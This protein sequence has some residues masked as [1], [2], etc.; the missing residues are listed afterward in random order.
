MITLTSAEGQIMYASPSITKVFGYTPHEIPTALASDFIHPDD[1]KLYI[2]KRNQIQ[3]IPNGSVTYELRLKHKTGRWIWCEINLSN[4]LNESGIDAMVA[5]FRD[6]SDKKTLEQEK[7]FD[8]NNLNALI[9]NTDD[10]MWSVDSQYNLLIFNLPFRDS[11]I[12]LSGNIPTKG[13]DIFTLGFQ[14]KNPVA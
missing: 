14:R 8:R 11:M 4:L 3:K 12:S 7:E 5:N 6:I 10:L 2:E 13:S 1:V 9:N